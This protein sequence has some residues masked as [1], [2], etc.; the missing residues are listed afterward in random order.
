M[1]A[2]SL[3]IAAALLAGLVLPLA[4]Q[5]DQSVTGIPGYLDPAT[6]TFTARPALEPGASGLTR[7]GKIVVTTTIEIDSSIP[8]DQP[9]SCSVTLNSFDS[10]FTNYATGT[11]NAVRSGS[12]ATCT[13][14]INYIWQV[15]S[16][17]TT[18]TVSVMVSTN[19]SGAE[20]VYHSGSS[21]FTPFAVPSGTKTLS[22]TLGL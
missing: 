6:G 14:T 4:A 17:S 19:V 3:P 12:T 10:L 2:P 1:K 20:I 16:A 18:M 5:A 8:K 15:A 22:T 7:K 11:D 21:S 9:I 13:M